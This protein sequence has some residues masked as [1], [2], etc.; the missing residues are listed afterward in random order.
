MNQPKD[1]RIDVIHSIMRNP[2]LSRT[3]FEATKAPIG[4]TK[5]TKAK[6][7]ISILNKTNPYRN[8]SGMGGYDGQGGPVP[9]PTDTYQDNSSMISKATSVPG[10]G[11]ISK[12]SQGLMG[13]DVSQTPQISAAHVFPAAP[14]IKPKI[15][16]S[17]TS[18]TQPQASSYSGP[19]IV[20]YLKSTG[21]ASDYASRA[22]LAAKNGI[23]NYTG[24]AEQ[25]TQ[26][27]NKLK[28][29][30]TPASGIT[31]PDSTNVVPT[32]DNTSI[33]TP[34]VEPGT[35]PAKEPA[36]TDTTT[37]TTTKTSPDKTTATYSGPPTGAAH[38]I[39][40]IIGLTDVSIPAM[41]AITH[42]GLMNVTDAFLKNE[43]GS[44]KGVMNNPGNIKFKGLPG[45]TDSGIQA[46]DGGTF[47]SYS[48]PEAGK[49]A[50][51]NLILNAASGKSS[52][53][54]PNPT[55]EKLANTYTGTGGTA[56]TTGE[57]S[58]GVASTMQTPGP[59]ATLSD[60]YAAMV[61]EIGAGKSPAEFADEWAKAIAQ[62]SGVDPNGLIEAK[63]NVEAT[64]ARLN[65]LSVMDPNLATYLQD[66]VKS[67]DD[68]VG[69]VDA[70]IN[71]TTNTLR[72]GVGVTS[73]N[74]KAYQDSLSFLNN[75]KGQQMDNYVGYIN[76]S[77][78]KFNND[79]TSITSQYNQAQ[80]AYDEAMKNGGTMDKD[81]YD[82]AYKVLDAAAKYLTDNPGIQNSLFEAEKKKIE[83]SGQTV[84][85]MINLVGL[86]GSGLFTKSQE[87]T[88]AARAGFYDA[89]DPTWINFPVNV[90]NFFVNMPQ[91]KGVD[92]NGNDKM[93]PYMDAF[94]QHLANVIDGSETAED[95][96]NG[97]NTGEISQFFP[98]EVKDYLIKQIPP[99]PPKEAE[100][101]GLLKRIW[102]AIRNK[103]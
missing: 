46:T 91:G 61:R 37:T 88:G 92:I 4:S 11:L 33:N 47:A 73:D 13:G 97:I 67:H 94:R 101:P 21:G 79:L 5:K 7:I 80:K 10:G 53:Y 98:Q 102:N 55:F 52:A 90:K 85:D 29:S 43:G 68:L 72:T 95:V 87:N 8:F 38:T 69:K 36:V 19:S 75:I 40:K 24:S 76:K 57:T 103:K 50:V 70:M 86:G 12:I 1:K 28:G 18:V 3:F 41:D 48:T 26:L 9:S 93:M 45:Q 54:G 62:T 84:A 59:G 16:S 60:A 100:T 39:A 63:R 31:T 6:S 96:K 81:T 2:K 89:T 23:T 83:A 42:Y 71:T 66:Y 78:N 56:S 32:I 64:G 82:N 20:D 74:I 25:N 99:E 49:Q 34:P 35:P 77:I 58:T 14:E 27:L 44:P 15:S 17:T 65:Q 22:A 30:G 51:S